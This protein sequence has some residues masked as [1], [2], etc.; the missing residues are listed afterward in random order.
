MA[1]PSYS[2]NKQAK[3]V[4]S[5]ETQV[6]TKEKRTQIK[7]H[8]GMNFRSQNHEGINRLLHGSLETILWG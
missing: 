4:G 7:I 5:Y 8:E 1:I 3:Q 6:E 2:G